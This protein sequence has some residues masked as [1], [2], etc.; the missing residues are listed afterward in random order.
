M[1]LVVISFLLFGFFNERFIA[2]FITPSRNVSSTPIIVDQNATAAGSDPKI[3]IPKINVEVPVVYD[4]HS[5]EEKDVQA[6]LERGVVHYANTA[7]PGEK[8]NAVIV[9]HSSNNIF[10]RGKYKFV[11]VLLNKLEPGDTFMVDKDGKRYVYK[12][13]DKRVVRPTDVSVLGATEKPAT[14]TLITCDPPGTS[15]NRLIVVAE[16]ISPDPSQNTINTETATKDQRPS[17]VPGNAPSLWYRFTHW[18]RS[19]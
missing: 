12:V 14:I 15:I 17:V 2:P 16:Q 3:I 8:G 18:L 7:L 9:G 10:N 13:Y 19:G 1:G 5:I 6:A 11:F 4:E